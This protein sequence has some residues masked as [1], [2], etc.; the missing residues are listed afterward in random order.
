[1]KALR[2]ALLLQLTLTLALGCILTPFFLNS[3]IDPALAPIVALWVGILSVFA[4][5][6]IALLRFGSEAVERLTESTNRL[7]SLDPME[8]GE[9][10]SEDWEITQLDRAVTSAV[11]M[12]EDDRRRGE[13]ER[14]A[15]RQILDGVGEGLIAINRGKKIVLAN[16]RVSEL[17]GVIGPV[18]GRAYVEIVRHST[19]LTALDGALEGRDTVG[20]MI[21]AHGDRDRTIEMRVFPLRAESQIAAVAIFIDVSQLA[22]L[23]SIRSDFIADF[24]HEART[25][26]TGLRSALETLESG[27]LTTNEEEQLRGII[28]RQISRLERLVKDLSELNRI[29]S[30]DLVLQKERVDLHRLLRTLCDDLS[31]QISSKGMTIHLRGDSAF[32]AADSMRLEQ[33]FTN[34]IDN[35]VKHADRSREIVVEIHDGP[36][37]AIVRVIDYGEGIPAEDQQRIFHRFYRMDKSRSQDVQGMGLGLAIVKHLVLL[38]GG[39][40]RVRSQIGKGSTF[41]VVFPKNESAAAM[42]AAS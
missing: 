10:S 38:H 20:R 6:T 33:I 3:W 37:S 8:Q 18:V 26:I 28:K 2:R 23:E 7:R 21:L 32:V 13:E 30:G 29:E 17:F 35:A 36:D 5:G 1:M 39:T 16:S 31:D 27:P 22:R 19:L 15:I 34:L 11:R 25:P 12:L 24:S 41:E 14:V 42:S 9:R 4:G 40:V